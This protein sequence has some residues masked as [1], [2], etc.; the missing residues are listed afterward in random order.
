VNRRTLIAGTLGLLAAPLAAGAQRPPGTTPRIGVLAW[1]SAGSV[2]AERVLGP[3]REGLRDLGYV[4]GQTIAIEWRYADERADR[5]AVLAADLVRL[6]VDVLVAVP[7]PAGLA[8]QSATHTVPIVV[9]AAGDPVGMGLVKSLA[10]PG[11]NVTGTSFNMTE[12]A[13]KHLELL[14][15]LLPRLARVAFLTSR[16]ASNV[17][18]PEMESAA[19]P[20]KLQI[21]LVTVKGPE[22]LAGAFS[23]IGKEG[24]EAVIVRPI[25]GTHYGK[26]VALAS[27]RRLPTVSWA[28]SLPEAGGLISYGPVAALGARR[29]ASQVDKILKGAKPADLPVEQPTKYELVINLKTAKALGLTIPPSV[30]ARADEVIQ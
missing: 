18:L 21:R 24:A 5:A 25:D 10:R 2:V 16:D 4:E 6:G 15:E 7:G 14:R 22:E 11:G 13:G 28:R 30:L 29:A 8:A 17:M 19:R 9:M 1:W 23:A 12:L 26:L 27:Q 20:L 3:F